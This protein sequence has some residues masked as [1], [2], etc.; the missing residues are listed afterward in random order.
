MKRARMYN[1]IRGVAAAHGHSLE[2]LEEHIT[3]GIRILKEKVKESADHTYDVDAEFQ[4]IATSIEEAII[5]KRSLLM[6]LQ[7]YVDVFT[8]QWVNWPE[9]TSKKNAYVAIQPLSLFKTLFR[10][11]QLNLFS[12]NE[13]VGNQSGRITPFLMR[14]ASNSGLAPAL[15]KQHLMLGRENQIMYR[16]EKL[17]SFEKDISN[18]FERLL[19]TMNSF[20]DVKGGCIVFSTGV[21]SGI[22]SPY[23]FG[24]QKTALMK[25]RQKLT[26]LPKDEMGW[27]NLMESYYSYIKGPLPLHNTKSDKAAKAKLYF[28]RGR[29]NDGYDRV[30]PYSQCSD[31]SSDEDLDDD[32]VAAI[33][34]GR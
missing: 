17:N 1:R 30:F 27:S 8:P 21:L 12:M 23:T 6:L 20:D 3:K 34:R 11:D 24:G 28:G 22:H 5:R 13:M 16:L 29:Q 10:E 15:V 32:S 14:F 19:L 4:S 9:V 2:M 18:A 31:D 26:E 25:L 7:A 33:Y